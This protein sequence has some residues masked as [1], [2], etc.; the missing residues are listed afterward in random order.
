MFSYLCV[1][2]CIH[3]AVQCERFSY[4][5]CIG[6]F[7]ALNGGDYVGGLARVCPLDLDLVIL[8]MWIVST[9][10]IFLHVLPPGLLQGYVPCVVWLSRGELVSDY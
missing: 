1:C 7:P 8:G 9:V 6:T 4:I 10:E 3:P 5:S 2:V